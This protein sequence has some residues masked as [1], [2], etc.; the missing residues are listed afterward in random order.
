MLQQIFGSLVRKVIGEVVGL[1][2]NKYY[3]KD[4]YYPPITLH[5]KEKGQDICDSKCE[6]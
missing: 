6:N 2:S 3:G 4:I 1:Y 5:F